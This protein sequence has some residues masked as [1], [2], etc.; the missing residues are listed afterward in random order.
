MSLTN[1]LWVN[2]EQPVKL[3]DR[4]ASAGVG[5]RGWAEASRPVRQSGHQRVR[6]YELGGDDTLT[7]NHGLAHACT[8]PAGGLPSIIQLG[9]F[10]LA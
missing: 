8:R 6:C 7:T 1:P 4:T 2:P 10:A 3:P 9:T 5:G